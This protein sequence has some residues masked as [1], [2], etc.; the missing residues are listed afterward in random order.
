[1]KPD[2]QTVKGDHPMFFYLYFEL[3]NRLFG[4]GPGPHVPIPGV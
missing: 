2:A 1:M 3:Y 4:V